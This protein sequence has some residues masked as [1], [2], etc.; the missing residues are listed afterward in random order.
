M[1]PGRTD[2]AID[3]SSALALAAAAFA[4]LPDARAEARALLAALTGHSR[5]RL[6]AF[7]EALLEPPQVRRLTEWVSR[8]AHGEPLAYLSG[9]RGFGALELAVS[10]A[11]LVPRPETELLVELALAHLPAPS[12][13][14]RPAC[15]D[16][17]TGSGAIA[18]ACAHARP[19]TTWIAT[20]RCPRALAVAKG[21]ADRLGI[22]NVACV[23]ARWWQGIGATRFDLVTSN[24]PY[25]QADDPA[26]A[27]DGLRHEPIGAL[28]GGTDGLSDLAIISAG[29]PAHLL[30]GGWLLL[31]HG[32]TQGKAVRD[33]L[34]DAGFVAV[35]THVDLAGLPRVSLGRCPGG[36]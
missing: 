21:N 20:D 30:P 36:A 1:Q 24:P 13:G 3:V 17:G 19:D 25:L 11:V 33:R 10:P 28:V 34:R 7:P 2:G 9:W 4:H 6:I 5:S 12:D 32:A 27:G 16:L 31:E 23:A 14:Q 26:L 35:A 22:G 29:A 8:R 15:L 18:L